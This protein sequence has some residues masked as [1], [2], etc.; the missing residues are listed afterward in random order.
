MYNDLKH[1]LIPVSVEEEWKGETSDLPVM[2][3]HSWNYCKA[4]SNSVE[5]EILLAVI[6]TDN[7]KICCPVQIRVKEDGFKDIVTPYGFGGILYTTKKSFFNEAFDEWTVFW[8][9]EGAVTAYIMQHPLLRLD[10]GIQGPL[11]DVQSRTVYLIDLSLPLKQIWNNMSSTHRYEIRRLKKEDKL[12]LITEKKEIVDDFIALYYQTLNRV[13][14]SRIY[15]FSEN[16][17]RELIFWDKSIVIGVKK[18]NIIVAISMF[19]FSDRCAEYFLSASTE[20]G[21]RYSRLLIWNA[22]EIFKELSIPY[23]NLGGG[24]KEN[25]NLELFKKRFGGIEFKIQILKQIFDKERY[26][27][28]LNKYAKDICTKYFPPYWVKG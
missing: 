21:R 9:K 26:E 16:T 7:G 24:V 14:A 10:E 28:L 13:K 1:K 2:A 19:I 27:Y 3:V 5:G 23:I 11:V 22:I 20:A 4:M 6:K 8:R 18:E 25:D 12:I 15:Y 17:L